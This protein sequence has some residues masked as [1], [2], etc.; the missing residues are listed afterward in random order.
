MTYF[1]C[2]H[3]SEGV[4]AAV[5]RGSPRRMYFYGANLF[6]NSVQATARDIFAEH[7]YALD[8]AAFKI[9]L[10]VHD[11]VVIEID[12]KH[13]DKALLDVVKFMSEAPE[14]ASAVPLAAEGI[15]T[16]EYTK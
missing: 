12:E 11:E 3:E 8:Q 7:L 1:R 5:Q 2:R 6:Q 14:W 10:H 4:T 13:S 16:K 15:V 9:I